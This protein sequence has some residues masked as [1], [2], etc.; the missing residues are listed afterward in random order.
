MN[1]SFEEAVYDPLC[2]WKS[3][4]DSVRLW[5]HD[6]NCRYRRLRIPITVPVQSGTGSNGGAHMQL[7]LSA[8]D[9]L[10]GCGASDVLM[11]R[12][13]LGRRGDV[14]SR[15]RRI[16]V[17]CGSTEP[18]KLIRAAEGGFACVW[19]PYHFSREWR[20]KDVA[21]ALLVMV[22]HVRRGEGCRRMV[23]HHARPT[24]S[25]SRFLGI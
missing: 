11:E 18:E 22:P 20:P 2:A 3:M 10:R 6:G 14:L 4:R 17:E 12:G 8:A 24:E 9:W 1:L 15:E 19:L 23:R 16:A 5:D 7:K 21:D 13:Y 25:S